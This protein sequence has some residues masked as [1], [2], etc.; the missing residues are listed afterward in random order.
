VVLWR[1]GATDRTLKQVV[2]GKAYADDRGAGVGPAIEAVRPYAERG[3]GSRRTFL[4]PRL[5]AYLAGARMTL[6]DAIPGV[7]VMTPLVRDWV[8][9]P[10][11][12]GPVE[13]LATCAQVAATLHQVN[14]DLGPVRTL[15]TEY[16]AACAEVAAVAP[17]APALADSLSSALAEVRAVLGD[18]PLPPAF[19]HGDLRP[20]Q[21][22]FDGPL[23]GMVDFDSVCRAEPALDLGRFTAHL[24]VTAGKAQ[25]AAGNEDPDAISQL[26][27]AFLDAYADAAG[28]PDREALTARTEA[29]RRVSLAR[30]AVMS[31]RQLKPARVRVAQRLALADRS[32]ADGARRRAPART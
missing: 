3:A 16:D 22:L 13:A 28:V 25:S 6:L 29:Y 27:A 23:R 30:A 11:G 19:G 15:L 21:F 12:R 7:P 8:A 20:G 5:R 24:A 1:L 2:F 18:D 4:V 31:W 9:D 32:A 26:L 17:L 10:V 14:S